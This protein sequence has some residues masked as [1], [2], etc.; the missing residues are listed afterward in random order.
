MS[1]ILAPRAQSSQDPRR[2]APPHCGRGARRV[3]GTTR[4]LDAVLIVAVLP[5]SAGGAR[6]LLR[7][8]GLHRSGPAF[9]CM[10]LF[11]AAPS[12]VACSGFRAMPTVALIALAIVVSLPLTFDPKGVGRIH[13]VGGVHDRLRP[14]R[15]RATCART[16]GASRAW[17]ELYCATA[18]AW[19][20]LHRSAQWLALV[21]EREPGVQL[22]QL[23]PARFKG[24]W[25]ESSFFAFYLIPPL[26][27]CLGDAARTGPF[28]SSSR[29]SSSTS[30]SGPHRRCASARSTLARAGSRS[31]RIASREG[32]PHRRHRIRRSRD[33]GRAQLPA[34]RH[35]ARRGSSPSEAQPR[36]QGT[37]GSTRTSCGSGTTLPRRRGSSPWKDAISHLQEAPATG[38]GIGAYGQAIARA[39]ER[40]GPCRPR[41]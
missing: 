34:D 7:R 1:R 18:A 23:A 38:V 36:R 25:Q 15:R 10:G 6:R 30:R 17:V 2:P 33:P 9:F 40:R 31:G 39:R 21:C 26:F 29:S 24:P 8:R 20:P 28:R 13:A 19:G 14:R 16:G 27:L 32:R 22:A 12:P 11:L 3:A 41:C 4:T 5:A 35:G 37:S